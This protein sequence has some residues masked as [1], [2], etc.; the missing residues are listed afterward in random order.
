[1]GR[2]SLSGGTAMSGSEPLSGRLPR[3]RS[4]ALS[5]SASRSEL[6]LKILGA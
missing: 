1:M 3:A 4:Q 5:A 2:F 6:G